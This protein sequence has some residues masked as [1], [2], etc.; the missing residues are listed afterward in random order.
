M[1]RIYGGIA[2][3]MALGVVIFAILGLAMSGQAT[4]VFASDNNAE[5]EQTSKKPRKQGCQKRKI[6]KLERDRKKLQDRNRKLSGR[7]ADV[8]DELTAEKGKWLQADK[9]SA[10]KKRRF[11][12]MERMTRK[13]GGLRDDIEFN[14]DRAGT[15]DLQLRE[16]KRKC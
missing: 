15:I 6:A 16:L 8:A 4:P 12:N 1:Q 2:G 11:K 7:L 14:K 3:R 10:L 9:G 5:T 13:A